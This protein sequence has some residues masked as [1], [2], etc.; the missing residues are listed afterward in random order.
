MTSWCK[1]WLA[2]RRPS[3]EVDLV[4]RRTNESVV[5]PVFAVPVLKQ[6]QRVVLLLETDARVPAVG[7]PA[8]GVSQRDVRQGKDTLD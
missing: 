5:R 1:S 3:A 6:R 7:G 2:T 4:R 8:T